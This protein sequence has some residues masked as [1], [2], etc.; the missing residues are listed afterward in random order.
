ME[1]SPFFFSHETSVVERAAHR[2]ICIDAVR[3]IHLLFSNFSPPS[4]CPINFAAPFFNGTLIF[5]I[6]RLCVF[7]ELF[8]GTVPFSQDRPRV[9]DVEDPQ[10]SA[11]EAKSDDRGRA[12]L[13]HIKKIRNKSLCFLVKKDAGLFCPIPNFPIARFSQPIQHFF[14]FSLQTTFKKSSGFLASMAVE[15]PEQLISMASRFAG[16]D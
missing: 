6:A 4:V 3:K 9:A 8:N 12:A 5:L 2:E 16:Y 7:A 11:V 1:I 14:N 15:N 13:T 10:I